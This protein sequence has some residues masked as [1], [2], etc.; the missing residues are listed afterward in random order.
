MLLTI[1]ILAEKVFLQSYDLSMDLTRIQRGGL[2][3]PDQFIKILPNFKSPKDFLSFFLIYIYVF[4]YL[5]IFF[6]QRP[7]FIICLKTFS[8]RF[9]SP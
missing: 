9:N 6:S 4:M 1:E 7:C 3:V 5:F 8:F 2:L